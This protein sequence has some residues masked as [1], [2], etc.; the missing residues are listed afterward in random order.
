MR[1]GLPLCVAKH[2]CRPLL[3]GC[4]ISTNEGKKTT[5][6]IQPKPDS[7]LIYD[8][9][10]F[11]GELSRNSRVTNRAPLHMKKLGEANAANGV[12]YVRNRVHTT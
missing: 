6:A 2:S 9:K 3:A 4:G 1:D 12:T 11:G 10:P 8:V 5:G 7:L